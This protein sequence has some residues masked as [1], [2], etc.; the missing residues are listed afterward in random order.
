MLIFTKGQ[1][2]RFKVAKI[3]EVKGFQLKNLSLHLKTEEIETSFPIY[4]ANEKKHLLSAQQVL[5]IIFYWLQN[6]FDSLLHCI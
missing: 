5:S 3:I 1:P 2:P 6:D 4:R